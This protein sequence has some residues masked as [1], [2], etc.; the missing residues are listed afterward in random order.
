MKG[1]MEE[2]EEDMRVVDGYPFK[3]KK[4]FWVKP[5]EKEESDQKLGKFG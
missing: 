5:G 3:G 2:D 1:T 4:K